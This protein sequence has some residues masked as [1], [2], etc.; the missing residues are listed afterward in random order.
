[1]K[2]SL[3]SRIVKKHGLISNILYGLQLSDQLRIANICK[4]TYDIT[5]PWNLVIEFPG[6]GKDIS[7]FLMINAVS[8]DCICKV[9][10][11]N[12][13][14]EPGY[15]YGSVSELTG[16]PDGEGV[17]VTDDEW[18]HFGRVS[19]G[20]YFVGERLSI[21]LADKTNVKGEH[22]IINSKLTPNGV[23]I[24]KIQ[25]FN[26]DEFES[27]IYIDGEWKDWIV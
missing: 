2:K 22:H 23:F 6:K 19:D 9:A 25:T 14:G 15:F 18:I 8:A 11:A 27:G 4:R 24:E 20:K 17:F 3:G 5:V 26:S 7:F 13:R 16:L 21:T 1:M 10:R 12:I